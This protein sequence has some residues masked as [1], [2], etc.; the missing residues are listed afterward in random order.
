MFPCQTQPL[1]GV[2]GKSTRCVWHLGAEELRCCKCRRWAELHGE[3]ECETEI[4]YVTPWQHQRCLGV[5]II[6]ESSDARGLILG[7]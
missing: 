7:I 1:D 2:W 3:R 4:S 6:R 5:L